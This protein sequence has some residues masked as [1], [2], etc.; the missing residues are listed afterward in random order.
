M[1]PRALRLHHAQLMLHAQ[2]HAKHV[3]VEGGGIA[4]RGLLGDRAG[5]AFGA[6]IVDGD[7]EAA[8]P[9]DG[10]VDQVLHVVLAADV[11]ANEF[12]FRAGARSSLTSAWPASSRRPETTSAGAFVGEGERG[13]AAD[14]GQRA[15]DQDNGIAHVIS[16]SKRPVCL[17][18]LSGSFSSEADVCSR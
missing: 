18:G 9:G 15:G 17:L 6:G 3:G 14:A 5:R 2:E 1:L 10:L 7:V 16:P 13:G 8:E 11:G 4:L 12:G